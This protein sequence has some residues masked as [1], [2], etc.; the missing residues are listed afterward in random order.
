MRFDILTLFPEIFDGYLS[1][2]LLKRAIDRGLVDIHRWNVRDWSTDKHG[3]VDDRPYGGGPGMV[4]MCQPVFDAVAA[5]Q[6]MGEP[7]ELVLLS[8]GGAR[9]TH[10]LAQELSARERLVLLCG[11]YEGF[12]ERIRS[13]LAP[14]EIS[15]GDYVCN[16]GEVPA[17]VLIDS[18]IRFLPGVLGDEASAREDS[19]CRPD[20]VEYPQ[21][22]RPP[23][24]RG[25]KVPDVLL[26]GN[27]RRVADWRAEQARLRGKDRNTKGNPSCPS[28]P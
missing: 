20:W 6:A 9:W 17:M 14:R 19:F 28:R 26:S 7:G 16:G 13:G 2:S 3:K 25:Q 1:Q 12:D 21:Y 10:D 22:T 27:H 8:P 4:L 5:V 23:E 24:F 11:R 15:I 18:V